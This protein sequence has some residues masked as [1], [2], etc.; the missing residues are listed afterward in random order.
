MNILILGS[1]GREC[2]LAWKISKGSLCSKL[3]I[4]PGN[5]GT[6]EY[7]TNISLNPVDFEKVAAFSLE[8]N[9]ELIVVGPEDPLVLGIVDYFTTNPD[10]SGIRIIGPDKRAA[11]LEGSKSFA[12]EFMQKYDIPTASYQRFGWGEQQQAKNF[13]RS[14]DSPYVIKADGLAA[15]KGVFICNTVAEAEEAI[16]NILVRNIFG[17][18]GQMLVIEEFL[19]GIEMSAFVLTDGMDY[20]M[21]PEAKDYKRIGDGNTG[22]N[23]GGMGTVSPVPFADADFMQKLKTQI[24]EPTI[25]GICK[26]GMHYCGCIFF[27]LMNVDGNPYVIEYNVRFGDPET[28]VIM[29]RIENDLVELLIAASDK[30]LQN[31]K[32][33]ISEKTA[34][35]IV[36]ASKGY[37]DAY[38]KGKPIQ[39]PKQSD[40]CLIF[41]AG[42]ATLNEKT[43]TSGGRVLSACCRG[44]TLKEAIQIAYEL[45]DEISFENKYYR[46]DIGQDLLQFISQ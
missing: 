29:P 6:H 23:T 37:P 10:L 4:A 32:I 39:L 1:G 18:A 34:V 30:K 38:E 3:F 21:L 20:V 9:I 44:N 45:A 35:N 27:G 46:K 15:G 5:G 36:L 8:H 31:R 41:H 26:E 24:I 33:E 2:A 17:E 28:Q 14:L 19:D 42:T 13:L 22:P 7:G 16:D 11:Q 40:N 25:G 43:V 12:K